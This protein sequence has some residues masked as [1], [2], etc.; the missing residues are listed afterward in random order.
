MGST[1]QFEETASDSTWEV[2]VVVVISAVVVAGGLKAFRFYLKS[3]RKNEELCAEEHVNGFSP[4][5][6]D[7]TSTETLKRGEEGVVGCPRSLSGK[8]GASGGFDVFVDDGDRST[9]A[10][11][12]GQLP[13]S[14]PCIPNR[15]DDV[16]LT[17]EK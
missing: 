3:V 5:H 9:W 15:N 10:K 17:V 2:V 14:K 11:F 4:E 13:T 1:D 16:E 12:H 7:G 6:D 8:S